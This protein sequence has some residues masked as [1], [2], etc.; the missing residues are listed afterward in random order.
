[1]P[2]FS[3]DNSGQ[4]IVQYEQGSRRE[5]VAAMRY[6]CED[7]TDADDV[8]NAMLYLPDGI[9]KFQGAEKGVYGPQG[10]TW[11]AREVDGE[12]WPIPNPYGVVPVVEL[13][14]NRRLKPG[15]VGVR[16]RR[17][18]ARAGARSTASTCSP[19]SA[20]WWRSGWASRSAS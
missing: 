10:V 11:E 19:S 14:V 13:P 7:D 1:M 9:F 5:R 15:A 18:R 16:E 12:P 17:V 8:P 2:E 6:W 3:F 4:M 20:W